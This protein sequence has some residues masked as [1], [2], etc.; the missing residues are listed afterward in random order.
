M[1]HQ[2]TPVFREFTTSSMWAQD[3]DSRIVWLWMLLTA[4]PEGYVPA[5]IPGIALAANVSIEAAKRAISLLEA[6]D[7]YS[8]SKEHEGR[9]IEPVPGGWRILNFL[10]YRELAKAEAVKARQRAWQR[11]KR[12]GMKG[13]QLTLPHVDMGLQDVDTGLLVDESRRH[14]SDICMDVDANPE[15]VDAPKPK[16]KP[17][18]PSEEKSTPLPPVAEDSIPVV[19]RRIPEGWQMGEELLADAKAAGVERPLEWFEKLRQGPIG[20]SRGVFTQDLAAYVRGQFPKWRTWEETD[21]AKANSGSAFA[22][23]NRFGESHAP[24]AQPAAKRIPGLPGWV[25]EA[26]VK[27]AKERG[28]SIKAAIKGFAQSYHLPVAGLP[29]CDV[30][31]PF[32]DYIESLAEGRAA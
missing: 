14:P 29:P 5:A 8:R 12:S 24:E 19:I 32:L 20:G 2:Y 30:H 21:R 10:P 11:E 9:R 6:P 27:A 31:R 3:S 25:G 17:S 15:K 7:P 18:S 1:R 23:R 28:V 22:Q 16:P 13:E 4:D 26:H